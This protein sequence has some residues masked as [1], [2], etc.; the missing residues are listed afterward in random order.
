MSEHF[1]QLKMEEKAARIVGEENYE[2]ANVALK[3]VKASLNCDHK[4]GEFNKI[5][6]LVLNFPEESE[7]HQT[8]CF[9][10]PSGLDFFTLYSFLGG[11]Y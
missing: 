10:D 11:M 8:L 3:S 5:F 2:R 4:S 1:Q 9:L 6:S 7:L